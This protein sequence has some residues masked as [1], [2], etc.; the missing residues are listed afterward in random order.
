MAAYN[1]W[2]MWTYEKIRGA[3]TSGDLLADI[4]LKIALVFSWMPVVIMRTRESRTHAEIEAVLKDAQSRFRGLPESNLWEMAHLS[5]FRDLIV[6]VFDGLRSCLGGVATSKFL[7]FSRSNFFPMY[8]RQIAE[9]K[10]GDDYFHFLVHVRDKLQVPKNREI[11]NAKYPANLLRG[12]DI[13]LMETRGNPNRRFK[14]T[15]R[16]RR[17]A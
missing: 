12:W 4:E 6:P 9:I 2:Y 13:H 10:S 1:P 16:K 14:R 7:H 15:R 3:V 8:D 11:A 17:T 5:P